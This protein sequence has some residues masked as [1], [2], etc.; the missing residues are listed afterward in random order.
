MHQ[1][2]DMH[3]YYTVFRKD[4]KMQKGGIPSCREYTIY[5]ESFSKFWC[6]NGEICTLRPIKL[7][8]HKNLR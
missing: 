5:E 2:E 3:I 7:F 4:R 6:E 1:N 8:E